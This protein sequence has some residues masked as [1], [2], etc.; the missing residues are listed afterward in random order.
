MDGAGNQ[1]PYSLEP[2]AADL[3]L[4]FSLDFPEAPEHSRHSGEQSDETQSPLSHLIW[5]R[6]LWCANG[7]VCQPEVTG[8]ESCELHQ[9]S[10]GSSI[11]LA[12]AGVSGDL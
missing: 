5:K 3:S 7:L 10:A 8:S 9:S 12:S 11:G 1:L 2:L 6:E 4:F